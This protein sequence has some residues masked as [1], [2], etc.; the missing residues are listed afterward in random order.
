[1]QTKIQTYILA[2]TLA[3]SGLA[4][5]QVMMRQM[6]DD[7]D[8]LFHLPELQ[9]II[10]SSNDTVSVNM[11]LPKHIRGKEYKKITIEE[12]D[13]ILMVNAK[14]VAHVDVLKK[15]YEDTKIGDSIK[16][17]IKRNGELHIVNFKKADPESL[18][19]SRIKLMDGG[20][21]GADVDKIFPLMGTGLIL[22]EAD[23]KVVVQDKIHGMGI[24]SEQDILK[25]DIITAIN[26]NKVKTIGQFT[27]VYKG[28]HAD[29]S[30]ELSYLRN[31]HELKLS[32]KKPETQGRMMLK[33]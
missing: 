3:F 20:P 28:L 33:K 12:G 24:L 29:T 31:G 16:F 26:G 1:M 4:S 11:V 30:I 15:I 6:A 21:G 18:P 10:S 27:K 14:R 9:V 5:S 13:K 19:K 17:G 22:N 7:N 23:G 25:D 32:F 2:I 8:G